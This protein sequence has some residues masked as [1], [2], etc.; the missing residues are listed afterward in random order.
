MMRPMRSLRLPLLVFLLCAASAARAQSTDDDS[1]KARALFDKGM[2]HFHLEEYQ[3]AIEKWEEGFR[4]KPVPEFLYNVAQAYRLSKQP[5][6]ALS[7]YRKYLRMKPDAPNRPEVDRHIRELSRIVND[8][9]RAAQA[10]PRGM[11]KPGSKQPSDETAMATPPPPPPQPE[12]T[13]ATPPPPPPETTTATSST[14]TARADLTQ[15]SERPITKR[16]WFWPVVAGGAAVVVA[17][18]VVGV[19]VGTRGDGTKTLPMLRF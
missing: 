10:P 9:E 18:V 2:A 4:I 14:T 5:D 16:K 12:T 17:A 8:Q 7:F 19:V 3:Q 13:T 15:T 11:I 1:A 6:K